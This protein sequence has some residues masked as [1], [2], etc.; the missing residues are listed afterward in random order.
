MPSLPDPYEVKIV[1]KAKTNVF[2]P[3]RMIRA[4]VYTATTVF[5]AV[6]MQVG[7]IAHNDRRRQT[8]IGNTEKRA[9]IQVFK[10]QEKQAS[11]MRD[12]VTVK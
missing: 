9:C 5:F 10:V 1:Q 3:F 11:A 8:A 4:V 12:T 2:L 6:R 7:V